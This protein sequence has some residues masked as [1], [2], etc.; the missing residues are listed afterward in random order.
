MNPLSKLQGMSTAMLI[1]M[2]SI[3]VVVTLFGLIGSAETLSYLNKEKTAAAT[4]V[5]A[6]L[7]RVDFWQKL[8]VVIWALLM[9][10]GLALA[11]YGVY[12]IVA[13]MLSK[14]GGGGGAEALAVAAA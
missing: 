13:P 9:A 10:S 6:D 12:R 7:A 8:Y 2:G 5:P 3:V 4:N 11:G 1:T 14:G